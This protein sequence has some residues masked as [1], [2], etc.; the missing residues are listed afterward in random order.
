LILQQ[1]GRVKRSVAIGLT[2]QEVLANET[3]EGIPVF[4]VVL[5]TK[6][7]A[8]DYA[9]SVPMFAN[10][11]EIQNPTVM[12]KVMDQ[13]GLS[14]DLRAPFVARQAELLRYKRAVRIEYPR[15]GQ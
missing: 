10:E 5:P 11:I 2:A 4:G 1:Y 14:V 8:V 6:E 9:F 15:L 12:N 3:A 13:L 7:A